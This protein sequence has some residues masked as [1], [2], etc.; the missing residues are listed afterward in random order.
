MS[1]VS[2]MTFCCTFAALPR[3]QKL[4]SKNLPGTRSAGRWRNVCISAMGTSSS[5][6]CCRLR[7]VHAEHAP[8]ACLVAEMSPMKLSDENLQLP[9]ARAAPAAFGSR[10]IRKPAAI[11]NAISRIDVPW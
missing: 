7:R 5:T 4:K 1:F 3:K 6:I 8:R 9:I 11:L 2:S 10:L